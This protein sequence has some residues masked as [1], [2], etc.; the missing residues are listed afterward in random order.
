MWWS[1]VLSF[2]GWVIAVLQARVL[3]GAARTGVISL[4]GGHFRYRRSE[5][6]ATF[7]MHV[8]L[9]VLFMLFALTVAVLSTWTLVEAS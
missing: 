9:S 1:F 3:F 7:W 2:L 8:G 4:R 6:A 5:E